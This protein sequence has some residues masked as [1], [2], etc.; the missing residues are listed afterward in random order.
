VF[1]DSGDVLTVYV[2]FDISGGVADVTGSMTKTVDDAG[3]MSNQGPQTI[4]FGN[5][6]AHDTNFPGLIYSLSLWDDDLTEAELDELHQM[7]SV[8][9]P[10]SGNYGDYTSDF[11]LEY[12]FDWRDTYFIGD[13]RAQRTAPT[14]DTSVGGVWPPS[15]TDIP[16]RFSTSGG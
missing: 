12:Q 6:A 15:N 4:R 16:V 1:T 9:S 5:N 14:I 11:N 3:T 7:R 10:V 13:N 2:G 8:R